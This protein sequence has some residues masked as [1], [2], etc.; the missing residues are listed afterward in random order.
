MVAHGFAD[1]LT[2]DK[3][4]LREILLRYPDSEK[5]LMRKARYSLSKPIGEERVFLRTVW[6]EDCVAVVFLHDTHVAN[7]R[8]CGRPST[9]PQMGRNDYSQE[10]FPELAVP[11]NT[12]FLSR[13]QSAAQEEGSCHGGNLAKKSTRLPLPFQT[14]DTQ[15]LEGAPRKPR[16][17]RSHKAAQAE[18]R[19]GRPGKQRAG[20]AGG[21][22][23][24]VARWG[25]L[26]P[27]FMPGDSRESANANNYYTT[28]ST[29]C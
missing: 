11:S 17:S 1:L 6:E 13:P 3:K 23:A 12:A 24:R 27:H 9:A 7:D 4:T 10:D 28:Y 15:N 5:L 8:V 21:P 19:A 18:E 29:R 16:K 25:L 26:W 22:W 14:S 2:L 20:A